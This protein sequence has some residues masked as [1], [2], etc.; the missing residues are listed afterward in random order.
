MKNIKF[1]ILLSVL[2]SQMLQAQWY[3]LKNNVCQSTNLSPSYFQRNIYGSRISCV[4]TNTTNKGKAC[5][6]YAN[7]TVVIM[8]NNLNDCNGYLKRLSRKIK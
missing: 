6:I 1:Y 7:N 8:A 4:K 5:T 3:F 2:S